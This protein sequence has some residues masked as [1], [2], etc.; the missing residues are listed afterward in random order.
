[1]MKA[2]NQLSCLMLGLAIA[3]VAVP[4]CGGEGNLPLVEEEGFESR[5]TQ[6]PQF[7]ATAL[8]NLVKNGNFTAA[9]N[10]WI[11]NIHTGV[12]SISIE[13]ITGRGNT[14]KVNN[15]TV[16][17]HYKVQIYQDNISLTNGNCYRISF[18][19]KGAEPK[20]IAVGMGK[21]VPDWGSYGLWQEPR[22]T[23]D[24]KTHAFYFR[25]NA[26]ATGTR[27]SFNFGAANTDIWL[28]NVR[29]EDRGK[30]AS[31]P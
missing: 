31:C 23:A 22:L 17:E 19:A 12:G 5:D 14:V 4:A 16:M 21:N 15:P 28:D 6:S 30:L 27:L 1:M 7:L 10:E 24:W 8:P 29:L 2:K 3:C 18:A 9:L 25:A 11:P 26:T 20:Q 13:T